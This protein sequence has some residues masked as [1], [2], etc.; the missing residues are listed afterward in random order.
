MR[1]A[2]QHLHVNLQQTSAS[3][4]AH[5][6]IG[7]GTTTRKHRYGGPPPR[8]KSEAELQR[9]QTL[10]WERERSHLSQMLSSVARKKPALRLV[11]LVQ[12]KHIPSGAQTERAPRRKALSEHK[13]EYSPQHTSLNDDTFSAVLELGDFSDFAQTRCAAA[14]AISALAS[15]DINRTVLCMPCI[16]GG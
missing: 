5:A 2:K 14:P 8:I 4:S 3:I 6:P 7:E 15:H 10:Q 16:C 1:R 9:E 13:T 12:Q 11:P